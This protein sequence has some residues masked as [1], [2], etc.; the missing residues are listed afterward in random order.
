M[1]NSDYFVDC[2]TA[3]QCSDLSVLLPLSFSVS[4]SLC[5]MET[6]AAPCEARETVSAETVISLLLLLA[7]REG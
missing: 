5:V 2:G 6:R 1:T 3:E 7:V 4:V